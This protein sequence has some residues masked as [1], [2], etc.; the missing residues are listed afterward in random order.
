M[1]LIL[2][3]KAS[4]LCDQHIVKLPLEAVQLLYTAW[5]LL[6]SGTVWR[7][8]A[9][10]NKQKTARGYKP[11]HPNHPWA[12][13]VR[14][15]LENYLFAVQYALDLCAEYTRRYKRIHAIEEHARWLRDNVPPPLQSKGLSPF[16]L[17]V[18]NTTA[19]RTA[20]SLSEAVAIYR[21]YYIIDKASMARYRKSK[22]P[23]WLPEVRDASPKRTY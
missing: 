21:R 10:Y 12:V 6:V 15:S 4:N 14:E 9:P 22:R 2:L 18:K 16:P 20:D 11:T 17:C 13:W 19:Q 1:N 5:A 23:N 8:S 3:G 7:E